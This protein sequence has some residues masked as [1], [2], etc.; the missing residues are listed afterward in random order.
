MRVE[1]GSIAIQ[2]GNS[3]IGAETSPE[4]PWGPG[5]A[6]LV[7]EVL[8]EGLIVGWDRIFINWDATL[9]WIAVGALPSALVTHI[10]QRIAGREQRRQ[11]EELQNRNELILRGLENAGLGIEYSRDEHGN[12]ISL[13]KNVRINDIGCGTDAVIVIKNPEEGGNK[14]D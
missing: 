5:K 6:R 8:G 2:A 3:E 14:Y 13:I 10:F 12:P 1:H 4:A 9:F 7:A 11:F